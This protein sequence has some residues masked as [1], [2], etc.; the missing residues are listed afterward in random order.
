M[1]SF[2]NIFVNCKPPKFDCAPML[3]GVLTLFAGCGLFWGALLPFYGYNK[4]DCVWV[5]L[6]GFAMGA[7]AFLIYGIV[8]GCIVG[9]KM[10]GVM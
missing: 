3:W 5:F 1:D 4:S 10:L 6:S 2:V 8:V 9:L 7:T